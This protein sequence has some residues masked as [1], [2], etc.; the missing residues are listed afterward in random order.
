MFLTDWMKNYRST[1]YHNKVV[2]VDDE[3]FSSK[4]E[5]RRWIELKILEDAGVIRNLQRQVKY[6]LIPA[7][8][9]PETISQRGR[10][11]PG[12]VIEREVVYISD[13]TYEQDGEIVV[14]DIK[15]Y[16]ATNSGAYRI[17]SIKRKLML[18]R[19]GIRIREI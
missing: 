9:E 3:T 16:T 19:F 2:K 10:K 18:E 8:R 5:Y 15:G 17:F 1:K 12:K 13:F 4:K 7:Q 6:V 11:I 14:E